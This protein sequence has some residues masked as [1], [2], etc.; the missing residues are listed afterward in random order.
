MISQSR[1]DLYKIAERIGLLIIFLLCSYF[2]LSF[3]FSVWANYWPG[4]FNDFWV[5][6]RLITQYFRNDLNTEDL[7][8]AHNNVHRIVVPRFLFLV[9]YQFFSGSNSFLVSISLLC[10]LIFVV[11]CNWIFRDRPWQEKLL[12]NGLVFAGVFHAHNVHNV[13]Y[14]SNMQWDLVAVFSL[15]SVYC[16]HLAHNAPGKLFTVYYSLFLLLLVLAMLSQAGAFAVMPVCLLISLFNKRYKV[17]FSSLVLFLALFYFLVYVLPVSDPENPVLG[18]ALT[19]LVMFPGIVV[20]FFLKMLTVALLH[21]V[22]P[23]SYIFAGLIALFFVVSLFKVQQTKAAYQNIFLYFAIYLF[24]NLINISAARVVFSANHWWASRFESTI[25]LFVVMVLLHSYFAVRQFSHGRILYLSRTLVLGTGV[26]L[27]CWSQNFAYKDAFKL[28]NQV[29]GTHAYVFFHDRNQFAGNGLITFHNENDR[30]AAAD[31]V[32]SEFGLAYYHNKQGGEGEHKRHK[33]LGEGFF[34][35]KKDFAEFSQRCK[36][37]VDSDIEFIENSEEELFYFTL[38]LRLNVS[39]TMASLQNRNSYYVLDSNGRVNGFS[40]LSAKAN[41]H[42]PDIA[43]EGWVKKKEIAYVAE[44]RSSGDVD[45][46][47]Q[48]EL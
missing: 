37:K 35:Q 12:L 28:S 7:F 44:V 16:Y 9:D 26:I 36:V 11:L 21:Y 48:K 31:P 1:T 19:T 24:I 30:I 29:F 4:P 38:P 32:F 34:N 22:G 3:L 46:L 15:L 6:A 27:F 40:Y 43:L 47:Y 8:V 41:G 23:L 2:L 45:C 14:N 13:I 42:W 20:G 33:E 18:S 10:K 5:D 17:F 25:I 39:A